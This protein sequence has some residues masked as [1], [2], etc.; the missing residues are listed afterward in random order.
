VSGVEPDI[1]VLKA[2]SVELTVRSSRLAAIFSIFGGVKFCYTLLFLLPLFLHAQEIRQ[3]VKG[4]VADKLTGGGLEG[5]DVRITGAADSTL[6][7]TDAEGHFTGTVSTGRYQL[8]ITFTGYTTLTQELLVIAGHET[9]LTLELAPN[10]TLLETV[11]VTGDQANDA[12]VAGLRPLSIE[13]T[14]RVP[15]NFLDPVRA[16]ATYPGVVT[17]NDQGNAIIV[18][19]NSPN[20]LLWRI[21]GLDIVNPNHLANAGTFSDKPAANGGGVNI[22]SAQMLGHTNFYLGA[23]PINYG[24]ALAGVVDMGLR[25]GNTQQYEYTAQASLIGMDA[26]AEGPLNSK[27]NSSF[28]ANY[29]YSTVGLLGAMGVDFGDEAI[30]FQDFSFNLAFH[31]KHGGKVMVF[32]LGGLSRNDFDAKEVADRE[33]FKDLFD[34]KYKAYTYALGATYEVP[35]ANGARFSGGLSYS[36]TQQERTQQMPGETIASYNENYFYR[37]GQL[38]AFARYTK[39]IGEQTL[40]DAGINITSLADTLMGARG[41]SGDFC[42]SCMLDSLSGKVSGL[43]YQPYFSLRMAWSATSGMVAGARYVGFTYGRGSGVAEPRVSIY[44]NPSVNTSFDLAYAMVNQLQ[45]TGTYLAAGNANLGFTKSHQVTLNYTQRFRSA[46]FN[47]TAYYQ[48]LVDVPVSLSDSSFSTINLM[49]N[50]APAYLVPDG[51]GQNYGLDLLLERSFY[52]HHYFTAGASVYNSTYSTINNATYGT[53]FNGR[54]TLSGMYGREWSKPSRNRTIGAS[55]RA[56]YLGGLRESIIDPT[57]SELAIQTRYYE[58]DPYSVK[59]KDYFRIDLRVSFRKNKPGYTRTLSF[60]LQNVLNTQNEAYHYYDN[61]KREI[62]TKY[63]LG[64][65]P[66]VVYRIDF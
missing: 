53:R 46:K 49:E 59:L 17:A 34:I 43:L 11:T 61:Y 3:T 55:L 38:S 4:T 56:L 47:A 51:T 37:R 9:V 26:A 36:A 27:R 16:V 45:M 14:L 30:T 60:D 42:Q 48:K 58:R 63:Q 44:Y 5:A 32:G 18:H 28:L 21:N 20:G 25:E 54:Y 12:D 65:I 23:L 39:R 52:G 24:N 41:F 22:V 64:L 19:G 2:H 31:Q 7:R 13:K 66:M 33:E 1:C 10:T 57:A 29:R 62:T 6:L 8:R 50:V 35:L 40:L 15:A